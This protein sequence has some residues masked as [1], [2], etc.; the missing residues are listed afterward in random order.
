M[1]GSCG[2]I[3][4]DSGNNHYEEGFE[5]G[6]DGFEKENLMK[7]ENINVEFPKKSLRID[8]DISFDENSMK[9]NQIKNLELSN[10]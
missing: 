1:T 9:R 4:E 3:N 6:S 10:F 8:K 7:E 5:E 2:E